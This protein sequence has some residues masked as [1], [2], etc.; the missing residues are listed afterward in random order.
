MPQVEPERA[1]LAASIRALVRGARVTRTDATAMAAARALVDEAARLLEV[2]TFPGPHCQ[3]GFGP[4]IDL[5][6]FSGVP[7]EW[8]P[9]SPVIGPCNPLAPPVELAVVEEVVDGETQ[10]VV[11]GSV[12][13]TEPYNGPPWDNTHGGV[14]AAVFDELLGVAA[15][16]GGTGGYTGRLTVSY[17]RPTPIGVPLELRG[18]VAAVAGRKITARGEIRVD[19]T[20]TAEAEGLFIQGLA[21]LTA[22]G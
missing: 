6:D 13:L 3:M 19:G 18:W 7:A 15:L 4:A 8:F 1:R 11:T 9:F 2:D 17:R 5:V 20:L 22:G 14:V 21:T 16:A 10:K 12:T